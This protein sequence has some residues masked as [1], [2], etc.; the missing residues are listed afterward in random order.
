LIV[1]VA[2]LFL[3]VKK[4]CHSVTAATLVVGLTVAA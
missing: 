3:A 2:F 1:V 4:V